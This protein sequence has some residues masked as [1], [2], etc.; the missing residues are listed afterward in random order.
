MPLFDY[1]APLVFFMRHAVVLI[2]V[3]TRDMPMRAALVLLRHCRRRALF[4]RA[5]RF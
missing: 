2:L 4:A 3:D 5:P 1:D